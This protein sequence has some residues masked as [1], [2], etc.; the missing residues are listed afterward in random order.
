MVNPPTPPHSP[1]PPA[2][3]P[4][5]VYTGTRGWGGG[6]GVTYGCC[7]NRLSVDSIMRTLKIGHFRDLIWCYRRKYI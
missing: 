3:K 1:L 2:Q 4:E 5:R 7:H 6:G